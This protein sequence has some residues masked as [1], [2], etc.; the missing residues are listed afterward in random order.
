MHQQSAAA[1]AAAAAGSSRQQQAAAAGISRQQQAT[2][3]SNRQ[4]QLGS[5]PRASLSAVVPSY[6]T[7]PVCSI[8]CSRIAEHCIAP[9]RFLDARP[10]PQR[11][12]R[13]GNIDIRFLWG[14]G[15]PAMSTSRTSIGKFLLAT[16]RHI[17]RDWT[18]ETPMSGSKT[19]ACSASRT[20]ASISAPRILGTSMMILMD[21][22]LG[23]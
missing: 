18:L 21:L 20:S 23:W 11:C 19:S 9:R 22:N 13:L 17:P 7:D 4:Q 16:L 6:V 12:R 1:T 10:V 15:S 3:G 8:S 14:N 5:S 2:A